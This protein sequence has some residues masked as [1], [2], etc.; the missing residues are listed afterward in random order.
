[1]KVVQY[2]PIADSP[3]VDRQGTQVREERVRKAIGSKNHQVDKV[4]DPI[5][6]RESESGGIGM[7]KK[8]KEGEEEGEN[9]ADRQQKS[10]IT[11]KKTLKIKRRQQTD[12]RKRGKQQKTVKNRKYLEIHSRQTAEV[13]YN[14]KEND[15]NNKHLKEGSRQTAE[16]D[17]K[18]CIHTDVNSFAIPSTSKEMTLINIISNMIICSPDFKSSISQ[19]DKLIP[20]PFKRALIW[21]E[22][23]PIKKK[24]QVKEKNL[25]VITSRQWQIYYKNKER[26]KERGR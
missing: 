6:K 1:M 11:T 12:S 25:S 20:S 17:E 9:T 21:P 13:D 14:H 15:E 8:E 23:K 10:M 5:K 7:P 19:I 2:S 4:V 18:S 26:K 22:P 24:R 3:I 16:V